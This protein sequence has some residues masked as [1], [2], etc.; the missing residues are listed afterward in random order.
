MGVI[1]GFIGAKRGMDRKQRSALVDSLGRMNLG[2]AHHRGTKSDVDFHRICLE[3]GITEINVHPIVKVD[4]DEIILPPADKSELP[5]AIYWEPSRD[6]SAMRSV[7][8]SSE[9]LMV[10]PVDQSQQ[11]EVWPSIYYAEQRKKLIVMLVRHEFK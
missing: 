4:P 3:A 10:A 11:G 5:G 8:D 1:I 9:L 6:R 2:A 7:V